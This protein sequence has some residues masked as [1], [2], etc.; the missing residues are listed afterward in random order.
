MLIPTRITASL[1]L[2]SV[3]VVAA[4]EQEGSTSPQLTDPQVASF[5]STFSSNP[6]RRFDQ[7]ERL[8]NPL[9]AE[10]FIQKREHDAFDAFPARQDPVHFTDDIVAFMTT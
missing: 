1:A 9:T 8:G 2:L 10:V 4:C 7:V 3:V 6:N 5:D